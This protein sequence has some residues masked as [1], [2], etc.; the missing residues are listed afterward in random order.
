M[1]RGI[2]RK[3]SFWKVV[4]AYRS[5]WKRFW[6]RLFTFGAYGRRGIGW[7]NDPRKAVYNWWYNRTSISVYRLFGGK[8]SRGSC[9]FAFMFAAIFSIIASPVDAAR[10]VAIAR[11]E[12]A[13]RKARDNSGKGTTRGSTV[14]EARSADYARGT[15]ASRVATASSSVSVNI[16]E[17]Q[18]IRGSSSKSETVTSVGTTSASAVKQMTLGTATSSA[19]EKKEQ[20]IVIKS[21]SEQSSSKKGTY[22]QTFEHTKLKTNS[23]VEE[24]SNEP[25]EN[26]PKSTPKHEKDKY[27]RKRMIIE[28]SSGCDEFVLSKLR[29][30]AYFDI[31]SDP[32]DRS[33]KD[34]VKLLLDG[35]K[36]GYMDK[37]DRITFIACLKLR[38]NIYGVITD[39]IIENDH[40]KYEYEAWFDSDR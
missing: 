18:N 16:N 36:I 35:K 24:V 20:N 21:S 33:D 6:L 4:G 17:K 30:G 10:A 5:Q 28:S 37:A 29:I 8:A 7:F 39:I 2:I 38:R 14:R 3:P 34:A 1:S 31:E 11:R 13:K 26:T 23:A 9:F 12:K 22:I 32:D 19:T 25:D 40:T 27:I 15:S